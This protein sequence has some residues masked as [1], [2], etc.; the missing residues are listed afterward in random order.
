MRHCSA[1]QDRVPPAEVAQDRGRSERHLPPRRAPVWLS[2]ARYRSS[3]R[4]RRQP[5]RRVWAREETD[6]SS[7][8]S[9]WL[10]PAAFNLV[11]VALSGS[12]GLL[13]CTA[14]LTRD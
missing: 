4:S 2:P 8:L 6:R 13:E 11:H 1:R 5:A 12:G 10:S 9:S 3:R 14:I 7:W